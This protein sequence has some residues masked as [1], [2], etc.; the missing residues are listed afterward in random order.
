[1][2]VEDLFMH[3]QNSIEE[4]E[5]AAVN[6]VSEMNMK[7]DSEDMPRLVYEYISRPT[8]LVLNRPIFN[9]YQDLMGTKLGDFLRVRVTSTYNQLYIAKLRFHFS[10]FNK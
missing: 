2:F 6:C 7:P 1:M 3:V 10:C 5:I 9:H 4:R 8:R